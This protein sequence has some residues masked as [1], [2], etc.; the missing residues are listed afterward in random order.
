M[1]T[2]S[3]TGHE[4][5]LALAIPVY[6]Q[7]E[8][9]YLTRIVP[10]KSAPGGLVAPFRVGTLGSSPRC[11]AGQLAEHVKA[12]IAC[13]HI[14]SKRPCKSRMSLS[15]AFWFPTY[16]NLLL[17]TRRVNRVPP[18]PL[19]RTYPIGEH[20]RRTGSFSGFGYPGKPSGKIG[21][22]HTYT[23]CFP[24]ENEQISNTLN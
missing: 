9:Y 20:Y 17:L 22:I 1:R 18:E 16:L 13:L 3:W 24:P 10:A 12:Y 6:V 8:A 11:P 14:Y 5:R 2:M 7:T 15:M 23:P 21:N 4:G 19:R